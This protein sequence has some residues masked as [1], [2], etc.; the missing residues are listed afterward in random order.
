MHIAT[1]LQV[2]HMH[3]VHSFIATG[4]AH[5]DELIYDKDTQTISCISIGGPISTVSWKKD[6]L[7]IDGKDQRYDFSQQLLRSYNATYIISKLTIISKTEAASG[8]YTCKIENVKG[9]DTSSVFVSG[10]CNV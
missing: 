1:K 2:K 8:V 9:M 5:I 4:N 3:V 6:N 10:E 7:F